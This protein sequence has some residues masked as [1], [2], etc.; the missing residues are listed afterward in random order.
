MKHQ[1]DYGLSGS[2]P[3]APRVHRNKCAS[4]AVSGLCRP[5]RFELMSAEIADVRTPNIEGSCRIRF[6]GLLRCCHRTSSSFA[7]LLLT[8]HLTFFSRTL[9][10]FRSR[11]SL[12]CV[13]LPQDDHLHSFIPSS[14]IVH[15]GD[16]ELL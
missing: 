1:Q 9:D 6:H 8:S 7:L 13:A 16:K 14:Y 2:P 15:L 4:V 10:A 12:H 5:A 3:V 11:L